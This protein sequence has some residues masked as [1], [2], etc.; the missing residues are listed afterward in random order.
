[1]LKCA[2]SH[3]IPLEPLSDL[4][5][6]R[7]RCGY[8]GSLPALLYSVIGRENQ[9]RSW[10]LLIELLQLTVADSALHAR[11][12][13]W[14]GWLNGDRGGGWGVWRKEVGL[15]HGERVERRIGTEAE[16]GRMVQ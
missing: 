7:G 6:S 14:W 9:C 16:I 12:H 2:R 10:S 5:A 8:I 13:G 4:C 1:M 3:S 11:L 15:F